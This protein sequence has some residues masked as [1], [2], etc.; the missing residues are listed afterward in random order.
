MNYKNRETLLLLKVT[1]IFDR[2]ITALELAKA[3]LVSWDN[4]DSSDDEGSYETNIEHT[5]P[6][7]I[8]ENEIVASLK[9]L[10]VKLEDLQTCHDLISKH[11]NAL[12]KAVT[13]SELT[14]QGNE[15]VLSKTITERAALFKITSNA[16]ITTSSDFLQLAQDQKK[17]WQKAILHER[18]Q[19]LKMEET[20][21][22]LAK[23]QN[24]LE[25]AIRDEIQSDEDGMRGDDSDSEE[26]TDAPDALDSQIN[27]TFGNIPPV[28]ALPEDKASS[29]VKKSTATN[30]NNTKSS[31]PP[32]RTSIPYRPNISLSLWSIMKSCIGKDLSKIPMPVNFS[33]PLSMLQRL[34]E[35]MEYSDLL[36]KASQTKSSFEQMAYVVAFSI[37]GY[38]STVFRIGK[39][40]NPLL[41]ET[42]ELDR[43]DDMGFRM[44]C[45]QVGHHPPCAAIHVESKDCSENSGWTYWT[46]ITVSSKFRG[47]YLSVTPQGTMNI[48][49]HSTG[50]HYSWKKVTTTVN[51]IIVGKL[52]V[53]QS[54]ECE[55]RNHKT[56][57]VCR[58]KYHPYSYFSRD[59]RK[60]TGS[61]D[62]KHGK[63]H[64]KI[65]GAWDKFMEYSQPTSQPNDNDRSSSGT[66][67]WTTNPAIPQAD[68]MYH[69]SK[70]AMT[71]NQPLEG[72]AP[73]DCRNRPD[74]RLME[75]GKWDQAN[76]MK[77]KLEQAQRVRRAERKT[78]F[79]LNSNGKYKDASSIPH[80]CWTPVWFG[81]SKSEITGDTYFKYLDQYWECK[82]NSAWQKCT[83]IYDLELSMTSIKNNSSAGSVTKSQKLKQ[84]SKKVA[85]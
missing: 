82:Q 75:Q 56:G 9:M 50:N 12:Q 22:S 53:D 8:D 25:R 11:G 3:K 71:L 4:E 26:W 83:R 47:K 84:K 68:K 30:N 72:V 21:E 63:T 59:L 2:W 41:G 81:K 58:H 57:D 65:F 85:S 37:S 51:N 54:G 76:E 79:A 48:K 24:K 33:E 16:F 1:F 35:D 62:D 14:S 61:I 19:R 15:P 74:Q 42:F 70:L 52:W 34:G 36:H 5:S 80:D 45:E 44:I 73:T 46:D 64:L 17:R 38:A 60:V 7:N 23:Q 69:F 28:S 67:V 32:L 31:K 20:V 39:P 43:T 27:G 40:F 29:S 55:I 77:S 18:S 10:S 6:S 13:E 78:A 49:F 66:T